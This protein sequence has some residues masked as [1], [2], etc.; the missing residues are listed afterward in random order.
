M[1][2][3]HAAPAA[4]NQSVLFVPDTTA[5]SLLHRLVG[6]EG[7]ASPKPPFVKPYFA[8]VAVTYIPLLIAAGLIGTLVPPAL[9]PRASCFLSATGISPS[10][11]LFHSRCSGGCLSLMK[12]SWLAR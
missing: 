11:S 8:S 6:Y 4:P 5:A 2:I 7:P 12:A 9:T 1:P 3:D 10:R